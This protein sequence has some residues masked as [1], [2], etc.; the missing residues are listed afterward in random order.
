MVFNYKDIMMEREEIQVTDADKS[1]ARSGWKHARKNT[2]N[3]RDFN[4]TETRAVIK[5]FFL[6]VKAPKEI[7]AI[8]TETLA[9]FSFILFWSYFEPL[10]MWL[11]VLYA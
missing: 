2:R 1:L 8:L 11:Y 7:Q 3:A 4:D 9:C 5:L 6:Q 10:Y